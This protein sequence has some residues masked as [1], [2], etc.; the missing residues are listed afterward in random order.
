[1]RWITTRYKTMK[2]DSQTPP[3]IIQNLH[4]SNRKYDI[5]TL[6]HNIDHLELKRIL[7]TQVLTPEFC[8]KYILNPEEYGMCREDHYITQVQI[9]IYQPHITTLQLANAMNQY[10]KM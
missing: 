7:Q 5:E 6:E 1:M 3:P 10:K 8:V 4:L 9:L 2:N